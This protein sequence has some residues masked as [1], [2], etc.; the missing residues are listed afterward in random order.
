MSQWEAADVE[1]V[2]RMVLLVRRPD[3]R[4]TGQCF[5]RSAGLWDSVWLA[6]SKDGLWSSD[7][8]DRDIWL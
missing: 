2:Q 4:V 8:D 1:V 6:T 7:S 3:V 5:Q